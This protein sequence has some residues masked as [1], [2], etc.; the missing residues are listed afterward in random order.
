VIERTGEE[1]TLARADQPAT[2]RVD[3]SAATRASGSDPSDEP[4]TSDDEAF[5]PR[6]GRFL[7]FKVVGTGGMGRVFAAYD[8]K[9]DRRVALKLVPPARAGEG[10]EWHNR[11]VR[12]AQ[13]LARLSHPNVVTV[14]EVDTTADGQLY[15]VM[16]LVEGQDLARLLAAAPRPWREVLALFA[17]AGEGLA[18]AHAAGLIHRDFKPANVL[19]GTDG[20]VRVADF[21]LVHG[22]SVELLPR[23]G[24]EHAGALL[25]D[26][27]TRHG[28]VLGT[29]AYMAPEQHDGGVTDERSDIFAFCV[30]LWE[31]LYGA[32]PFAG[33]TMTDRLLAIRR[34][35]VREPPAGHDAP[36]WLRPLLL[37]GLAADPVDRWQS[38]RELLD[39]LARDPERERVRR[40]RA[41]L[42]LVGVLVLGGCIV[43]AGSLLWSAI[44]ERTRETAA[45]ARLGETLARLEVLR[46]DGREREADALFD[47]FLAAPEHAGTRAIVRALRWRAA[48]HHAAGDGEAAVD[49]YS[50]AYAAAHHGDD[51]AAVLVDLAGLFHERREWVALSW[52]LANLERCPPALQERVRRLEL[53]VALYRRDLARAGELAPALGLARTT[54]THGE[55]SAR[56]G[57]RA[58]IVDLEGDGVRDVVLFDSLGSSRRV[59]VARAVPGLPVVATLDLAARGLQLDQALAGPP[60]APAHL[61]AS[62]GTGERGRLLAWRGGQLV[63]EAAWASWA[64][65]GALAADV[66]HDGSDELY[67]AIGPYGRKVVGLRRVGAEWQEFRPTPAIDAVASDVYA[68]AAADLDGDGRREL[69]VGT[70]PWGAYDLRVL[71]ARAPGEP[72]E[73]LARRKLGMIESVAVLPDR[74]GPLLAVA[75]NPEALYAAPAMFPGG[76]HT[77]VAPG[78][79]LFRFTGRALEQVAFA[80]IEAT[81]RVR[82]VTVADLDGDGQPE[83]LA[84]LMVVGG[85]ERMLAIFGPRGPAGELPHHRLGHV[86]LL[87]AG[88]LDDDPADELVVADTADDHRVWTLG[89]GDGQLPPLALGHPASAPRPPAELADDDLLRDA[90]VHAG[91]LAGLGLLA[92]AGRRYA[93]LARALPP[94]PV[95]GQALAQAATLAADADQ[96]DVA[97]ARFEEAA[98]ATGDPALRGRAAD[99]YERLGRLGDAI[100]VLAE[101]GAMDPA[102]SARIARHAAL[103]AS[104]R[105]LT[106]DRPLA[107]AW[108]LIDPLAVRH[109]PLR[110]VLAADLM[111]PEPVLALPVVVDRDHMIRVEL[112]LAEVMWGG[113]LCL[114]LRPDDPQA[115]ATSI[116]VYRSGSSQGTGSRLFFRLLPDDP[117]ASIPLPRADQSLTLELSHLEALGEQRLDVRLDDRP[118]GQLRRALPRGP[119]GPAHLE[120][121]TGEPVGGRPAR[122]EPWVRVELRRV[123]TRGLHDRPVAPEPLDEVRRALVDGDGAAAL[124]ALASMPSAPPL[125]R[126][127]AA[128]QAADLPGA[129]A[130]LRRELATAEGTLALDRRLPA[131]RLL[132]A[133]GEA[134]GPLLRE[135][136]GD[137][138]LELF[139]A[140]WADAAERQ[141]SSP[142][143]VRAL[144]GHLPHLPDEPLAPERREMVADLRTARAAA[145]AHLRYSAEAH[146]ELARLDLDAVFASDRADRILY[147]LL[148]RLAALDLDEGRIDHAFVHL[149]ALRATMHP[150]LHADIL[151][152][153]PEYAPLHAD[154][155]WRALVGE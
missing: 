101:V 2:P 58:A 90:W 34:G 123:V 4:A 19:V 97:A 139:H 41:A 96:G 135:A 85:R 17:A 128:Q 1:D 151:R 79:Y 35:E 83:L 107:P 78:V 18:A 118:I 114:R 42:R 84:D 87:A 76:D 77:G 100:R 44:R 112:A 120:L 74:D 82:E 50:R 116:V 92:S 138:Y 66:D 98:R 121:L 14:H 130:E 29:P 154:P 137:A 37:R 150:E 108:R 16:E 155:R 51:V 69:A 11:L 104:E 31:A 70:G 143:L 122:D 117:S 68:L 67:A 113:G 60:G 73:Q 55:P 59:V 39:A 72:Y 147:R 153:N 47:A 5:P 91:E 75:K 49:A 52:V 38:V 7:V 115:P 80:A 81:T 43:Y 110:G 99:S 119:L 15:V 26:H 25:A 105:T 152:G 144:L 134:F 94:G 36:R 145:L 131:T 45:G 149:E 71:R 136:L 27:V 23:P 93:D 132:R 148:L 32:R 65:R 95:R 6:I 48:G 111:G 146:A 103:L 142:P 24:G 102:T 64:A 40:R 56:T 21:G 61:F 53:D 106:F 133:R 63:E 125:W 109:D 129:V 62:D 13:A 30:A 28:A 86:A 57:E 126:A 89:V 9:L 22:R 140:T 141:Q 46:D 88:N 20:R 33:S 10:I 54:L 127:V 3:S 124:A 12:E 8:P